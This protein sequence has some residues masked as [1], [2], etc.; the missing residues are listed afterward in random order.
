[1]KKLLAFGVIVLFIGLALSPSIYADESIEKQADNTIYSKD[2]KLISL[3]VREYKPDGTIRR[4]FVE[5]T[6]SQYDEMNRRL[7]IAGDLDERLSIYKDYNVV[8]E[9]I[10]SESLRAGMEEKAQRFGLDK[11]IDRMMREKKNFISPNGYFD[12]HYNSFCEIHFH[13]SCAIF[14]SIGLSL[15]TTHINLI[16]TIIYMILEWYP[17]LFPS[18][19]LMTFCFGLFGYVNAKNGNL[20]DFELGGGDYIPWFCG[21]VLTVGFV[22]Y[23]IGGFYGLRPCEFDGF[24]SFI[25]TYGND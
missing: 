22:G 8:S 11:K 4:Y 21:C 5:L 1:M 9:D 3:P 7:Q 13:Y 16:L 24:A 10:T 6:Q 19:D 25:C 17:F 18:V 23:A 20:P 2:D 15:F 14:P 12:L